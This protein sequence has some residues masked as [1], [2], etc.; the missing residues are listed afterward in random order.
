[1]PEKPQE[2][3]STNQETEKNRIEKPE[4]GD[5]ISW[6]EDQKKRSYYYDDDCGYEIYQPEE[7]GEEE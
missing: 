2:K 1:M 4:D 3:K 6:S 5:E 7:E